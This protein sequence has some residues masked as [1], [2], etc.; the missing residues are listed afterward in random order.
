MQQSQHKEL[1]PI[2]KKAEGLFRI[3][4]QKV[5]SQAGD[6]KML[7]VEHSFGP[8]K[9]VTA[10][11]AMAHL[12]YRDEFNK[13]DNEL[14]AYYK[15]KLKDPAMYKEKRD[16]ALTHFLQK[17]R[18][19]LENLIDYLDEYY[20]PQGGLVRA[21]WIP[22]FDASR[23]KIGSNFFLQAMIDRNSRKILVG[24][25]ADY[26]KYLWAIK[27]ATQRAHDKNEEITAD[28]REYLRMGHAGKEVTHFLNDVLKQDIGKVPLLGFKSDESK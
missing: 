9:A 6:S 25:D 14:D 18:H 28:T 1:T 10:E 3:S 27:K 22:I 12:G 20:E 23:K 13:E 26:A 16:R 21:T 15:K 17:A 24:E 2:M 11:E 19:A 7:I 5:K 8:R 4:S